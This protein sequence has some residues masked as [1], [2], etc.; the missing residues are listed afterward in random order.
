LRE[1]LTTLTQRSGHDA[2][3]DHD[4]NDAIQL[5][6]KLFFLSMRPA[7]IV[8]EMALPPPRGTR[9]R[10]MIDE[11]AGQVGARVPAYMPETART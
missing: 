10:A 8:V 2:A 6:D 5:A 1:E 7:S 3:G 11:I 4:L 9:S